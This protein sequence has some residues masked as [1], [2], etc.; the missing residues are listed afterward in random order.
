M[1]ARG[2]G[3]VTG[4]AGRRS[5]LRHGTI[6][7]RRGG[8]ADRAG[9][10]RSHRLWRNP[11]HPPGAAAVSANWRAAVHRDAVHAPLLFRGCR[12]TRTNWRGFRAGP[13]SVAGRRLVHRGG[14]RRTCGQN[15][16]GVLGGCLG[17]RIVPRTG[18]PWR[19]SL[20][21]PVSRG[22]AGRRLRGGR[23]R[24]DAASRNARAPQPVRAS[25]LGWRVARSC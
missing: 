2:D 24:R 17:K 7:G 5:C 19:D 15:R 1:V 25:N 4:G 16:A 14:H 12:V 11:A 23:R 6:R 18:I 20:A 8:P 3:P 21:G 10:W 13:R 22:H 9:L